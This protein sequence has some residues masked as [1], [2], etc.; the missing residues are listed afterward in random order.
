MQN[1]DWKKREKIHAQTQMH[2]S[3][4]MRREYFEARVCVCV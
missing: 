2:E 4:D 3:E 1:V